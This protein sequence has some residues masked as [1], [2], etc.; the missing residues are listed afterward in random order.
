MDIKILEDY[1]PTATIEEQEAYFKGAMERRKLQEKMENDRQRLEEK[2]RAKY[3]KNIENSDSNFSKS[4]VSEESDSESE[5]N[6]MNE[7]EKAYRDTL[8]DSYRQNLVPMDRLAAMFNKEKVE[9]MN[10]IHEDADT[11]VKENPELMKSVV[12]QNL[13]EDYTNEKMPEQ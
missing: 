11:F 8:V 12:R 3:G 5:Y 10:K 7:S 4:S 13:M 2:L 1:T 6:Q 9:K